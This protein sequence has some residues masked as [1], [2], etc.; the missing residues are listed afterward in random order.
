M[1][2]QRAHPL[3]P[4]GDACI[5]REIPKVARDQLVELAVC[6]DVS[7]GEGVAADVGR[8]SEVELVEDGEGLSPLFV[9]VFVLMW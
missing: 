1:R 7:D 3:E 5:L 9:F 6:G 8:G 2:R 4:G